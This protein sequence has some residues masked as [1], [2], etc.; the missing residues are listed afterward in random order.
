MRKN[1][2]AR[3]RVVSDSSS[4]RFD[5]GIRKPAGGGPEGVAYV[6]CATILATAATGRGC[7]RTSCRDSIVAVDVVSPCMVERNWE[8]DRWR[9]ERRGSA[10]KLKC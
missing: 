1:R 7:R 5:L 4:Q 9:G 6:R 3:S 10:A 2:P 8:R